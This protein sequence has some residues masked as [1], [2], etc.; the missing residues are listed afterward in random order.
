MTK[1]KKKTIDGVQFS[2]APFPVTEALRVKMLLAKTVGPTLGEV[3]GAVGKN[4]SP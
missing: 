3:V 4:P 1:A 2:V